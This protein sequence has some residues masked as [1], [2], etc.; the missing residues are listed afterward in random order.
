[1]SKEEI[2][3]DLIAEQIRGQ[4]KGL[5]TARVMVWGIGYD[6][7]ETALML[8]YNLGEEI[9]RLETILKQYYDTKKGQEL[10]TGGSQ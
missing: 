4:I 1:M 6:N 7:D 10:L 9:V 8:R 2:N 5:N 3:L